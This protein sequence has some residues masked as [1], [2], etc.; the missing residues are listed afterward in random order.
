MS[1]NRLPRASVVVAVLNSEATI[2]EC[3]RSLMGLRYPRELLEIVV[4]D[5]GSRDRT[6]AV[7]EG[8]GDSITVVEEGGRG[9]AAARNAGIRRAGGDVLAFTDADCTVAPEWLRTLVAALDDPAVGIA[10]GLILSRRPATDVEL[11]GEVIHDHRCALLALRPPYAI[12]MNWA[13]RRA[14]LEEVGLFDPRL[15]R[16]EDVDLAYRIGQRGYSFA[17]APGAVIYHRNERSLAGLFRE[18]WQHGFFAAPVRRRHAAYVKEFRACNAA[19]G[20]QPPAEP[21]TGRPARRRACERSFRSGKRVGRAMGRLWFALERGPE[22]PPFPEPG[23]LALLL[24]AVVLRTA[25]SRLRPLWRLL[26]AGVLHT[27]AVLVRWRRRGTAVYVKG[28]FAVDEPVYGVSDIDMIVVVPD[29]RARPGENRLQLRR[30]WERLCRA[31]PLL[32]HLVQHFW[33]YE[34]SELRE[35]ASATCL[36]YGL[37]PGVESGERA[38]YLGRAVADDMGLLDH[39]A[40]C[41]PQREWRLVAGP[42]RR[43]SPSS[44]DPEQRRI[45]GWLELQFLWRLAYL[46]SQQPHSP[47]VPYLCV[48]IVADP[49]R[50]WLWITRGEQVLRRREALER[51]LVALPAEEQALRRALELHAALHRSPAASLAEFLPSF[52]RLSSRIAA[53]IGSDA[54]EA[55]FTDVRLFAGEEADLALPP[56]AGERFRRLFPGGAL[57][58]QLPLVDWRALVVPPL[59]DE[60]FALLPEDGSELGAISRAAREMRA[61]QHPALRTDGLLLFPAGMLDRLR[62]VQCGATD[63][64]SFALAEGRSVASFPNLRGWSAQDWARRA[65]AEHRAWLESRGSPLPDTTSSNRESVLEQLARLLTATR[66]ALFLQTLADGEPELALP[67]VAVAERIGVRDGKAGAVAQEAV[68]A[69]RCCRR[70]NRPVPVQSVSALAEVVRGLAPYDL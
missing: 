49:V 38:A 23:R 63:P 68:A 34:E 5:N 48:K 43:G 13:S 51:G 60:T 2:A 69:Y 45:A 31:T 59:P 27:A 40:L 14:V 39:P 18:G 66:A 67:L 30:R 44:P 12:T 10:G 55:G 6:R 8:L 1:G 16:C 7:L 47:H 41:G 4:V 61:G 33:I 70:E 3:V 32:R 22:M 54:A 52:V 35:V 17:F 24:R 19:Q 36:T 15:R 11:F 20:E 57:P 58:H 25:Q 46:A 21:A 26:H 53:A 50:I 64:V 9:P 65:V 28:S 42:E 62:T 29:H 37:D 56:D